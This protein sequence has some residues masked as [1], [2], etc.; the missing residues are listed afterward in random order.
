MDFPE[1]ITVISTLIKIPPPPPRYVKLF[2]LRTQK[3]GGIQ[4]F[5]F[6]HLRTCEVPCVFNSR[7]DD[8]HWDF[9]RFSNF[10]ESTLWGSLH[11]NRNREY[12]LQWCG[13]T[14]SRG[15]GTPE[16]ESQTQPQCTS[17]PPGV[18][19]TEAQ[20]PRMRHRL[21]VVFRPA[22][23]TLQPVPLCFFWKQ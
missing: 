5:K 18:P 7:H 16:K 12:N 21:Q 20:C 17:E 8:M 15:Q 1:V 9:S 23:G 3:G 11:R 14:A 13:G 4:P 6:G 19:L 10:R 22:H 2:N